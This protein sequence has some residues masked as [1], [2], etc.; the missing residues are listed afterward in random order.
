MIVEFLIIFTKGR[1][2]HNL[3]DDGKN[4]YIGITITLKMMLVP[5]G[6]IYSLQI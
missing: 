6:W 2:F 1:D 3:T 4:E 5:M